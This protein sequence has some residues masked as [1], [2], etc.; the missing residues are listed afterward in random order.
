[1]KLVRLGRRRAVGEGES[2]EEFLQLEFRARDGGLDLY[3]SVYATDGSSEKLAQIHAEHA[4]S[5]LQSPP[6]G[7]QHFMVEEIADH[8]VNATTGQT[9]FLYTRYHHKELVF[10]D[11]NQLRE[12]AAALH[13]ALSS[14]ARATTLTD[15]VRHIRTEL[16]AAS[17][18][19]RLFVDDAAT[20]PAWKKL[21]GAK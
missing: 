16:G 19:W 6:R 7:G 15:I 4:A 13:A 14:R 11:P 2:A 17:D 9:R 8:R 1:M 21:V 10:D 3:P 12:F 18:E 5:F 20:S